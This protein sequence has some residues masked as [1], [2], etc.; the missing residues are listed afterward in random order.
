MTTKIIDPV[1][2]LICFLCP[3]GFSFPTE[4]AKLNKFHNSDFCLLFA[5]TSVVTTVPVALKDSC[6]LKGVREIIII[7]LCYMNEKHRNVLPVTV[8]A[9]LFLYLYHRQSKPKTDPKT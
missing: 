5:H 1:N 8:F 9:S 7:L 3:G 2:S 4:E 6:Q